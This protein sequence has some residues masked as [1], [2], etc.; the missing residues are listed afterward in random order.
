MIQK[1]QLLFVII[2]FIGIVSNAQELETV[3][4][5][6]HQGAVKVAVF[7]PDGKFLI[8][9]GRDKTAKLWELATGREMRTFQGHEGTILAL[10]FTPDGKYI[11]T[12]STDKKVKLWEVISGKLIMTF[13]DKEDKSYSKIGVTSIAFTS[14]AKYI[15]IGGTNRKLKIY[16]TETGELIRK[17]KVSPDIGSNSGIKIQ[18]SKNNKDILVSEDNRKAV[19][20]D[21]ETGE[22]KKTYNS[23]DK[24]SCGGCGTYAKYSSDEKYIISG[25]HNGPFVLWDVKNAKKIKT[26][27]EEQKEVSSVDITADGTKVLLADENSIY[28]FDTKTGKKIRTV[29]AHKK[30]LNYAEFSPDGKYIISASNDGTAVL[31]K[32]STGKKIRTFIGYLN[33]ADYGTKL[34]REEYWEFW[35]RTYFDYKTKIKLSPDG[36]LLII[37]KKDS[38]AKVIDFETGRTVFKLTGHSGGVICFDFSPD[39]KMIATGSSD[40]KVK[41]W[42]TTD[43]KLIKTLKAHRSMIFSVQFDKTNEKLLTSSYDGDT[44]I[45]DIKSGETEK[46][47]KGIKA[48]TSGFSEF[49]NYIVSAGLN[50][51][52]SFFEIDT[53]EKFRD[54]IGH[55]DIVTSFDFSFDGK[56]VVSASWDGKINIFDVI[57]GFQINQIKTHSG[58]I[59]SVI[60][61]KFSKYIFTGGS[62]GNIKMWDAKT[63]KKVRTFEGHKSAVTSLQITPDNQTL[64]SCSIEGVIKVWEIV[65]GKIIY[66]YYQLSRDDWFVKSRG[67]FFDGNAGAKKYIFYVKGMKTYNVDQ[68]FEDFYRPGLLQNA[69]QTRGLIN[70]NVDLNEYLQKSPP[71]SLNFKTIFNDSAYKQDI[72]DIEFQLIDNGGGINEIKVMQNGKRIISDY[73]G[74]RRIKRGNKTN[75]K[76]QLLLV[77]GE[78]NIQISAF[79]EGRIESGTIEQTVY[80]E[81]KE[82]LPDCYILTVG[83]DKYENESLNLNYAKA[84]AKAFSDLIKKRSKPLFNNMKFYNLFDRNADKTNIINAVN[85]I[86]KNAKPQDVFIFYYAGHGSMIGNDFYFVPTDCIRLYDTEQLSEK[87]I[88]ADY[89]QENFSKIKALKQIMILDAC[90]SGGATKVLGQRGAGREKAIAQLSRSTGIHVLASAGSEQFAIEFK[91]LGHGLFTY[92]LLD[93]LNGSADGSP[94]D[95]KVTIYE[96]KSY[97]DD[98]VPEYTKRFKGVRQY[99]QSYSGGNDFPLAIDFK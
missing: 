49:G 65:N 58:K 72:I 59:N 56:T 13:E 63:G 73:S 53:Q 5:R 1:R 74:A 16:L 78:N 7:S 4:Q 96:L 99:P 6:G 91:S 86:A 68:F 67:G 20:Y 83:I 22:I 34:D 81:S 93:A 17:I 31:W 87:A 50:K 43:G 79:S 8:T 30:E 23:I 85:E 55:T 97:L 66:T 24:G 71:P 52:F 10:C 95:G 69:Y 88:I 42:N 38:I 3:I 27:I 14:D 32:T 45:W 47:F 36:K 12:G 19:V 75:E 28:I 48:Y 84:D 18:L 77:P 33:K 82:N 15:A 76:I 39:G 26:Y 25:S 37:G 64:I 11:A 98:Q 54:Y 46:Y 94:L 51:K 61:S 35:A 90:Q 9:G 92:I 40:K 57:S 41:L 80:F 70:E 89:M 29:K 62:D 60:Y 21:F 44:Y 2:F